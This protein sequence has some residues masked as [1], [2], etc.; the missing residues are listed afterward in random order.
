MAKK[1]RILLLAHLSL[2]PPERAAQTELETADW[3]T[4]YELIW[5][6]RDLGHE[7]QTVGLY[8]DLGAI[9]PIE[10]E[11]RPHIVFNLM[12]EFDGVGFF[13]QN[14]V[15]YLELRRMRYTGCNPRGLMLARDKAL[16][17]KVL[18][19]HRIPTPAFEVYPR[20]AAFRPPRAPG[21]SFPLIVKSLNEEASFGISQRS[22]VGDVEALEERVSFLHH[23]MHTPALV[24]SY[25]EGRE[26]YVGCLG[27]GRPETF[28]VWELELGRLPAPSSRIATRRAK[29]DRDYRRRHRIVSR[30]AS[31]LPE[32]IAREARDLARAAYRALGLSGYARLDMRLTPQGDL[33]VLEANPNPH[34]GTDED[35][36]RSAD[37]G[38]HPYPELLT[39]ILSLGMRWRPER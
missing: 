30:E 27:N 10:A 26:L 4:E 17:K 33:F 24:E 3:R 19:F 38:G 8:D 9:D 29:W 14:L 28:P 21:L 34:I 31:G 1:L 6:L 7:V 18:A 39:K 35:F 16:A 2:V 23:R 13:D 36:A 32:P 20:G 5:T 15:S 25:I 11:L 12:E 37:R 22:V